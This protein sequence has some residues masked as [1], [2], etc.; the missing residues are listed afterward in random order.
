MIQHEHQCIR[1][2]CFTSRNLRKEIGHFQH[3]P[4]T[5]PPL[6]RALAQYST[7]GGR[8]WFTWGADALPRDGSGNRRKSG[9]AQRRCSRS[10]PPLPLPRFRPAEKD[11][12]L[13]PRSCR[14]QRPAQPPCKGR[15]LGRPSV[16]GR[17]KMRFTFFIV[18]KNVSSLYRSVVMNL[19]R[20]LV[21]C[22][23]SEAFCCMDVDLEFLIENLLNT[24][25]FLLVDPKSG[26]NLKDTS[27]TGDGR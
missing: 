4:E 9:S 23:E 16:I 26:V 7:A 10:N 14:N 1:W 19:R 12:P 22:E 24:S 18:L 3:F 15:A 6:N 2:L 17:N 5:D 25:T 21:R 8:P 20:A 11:P 27:E 13:N